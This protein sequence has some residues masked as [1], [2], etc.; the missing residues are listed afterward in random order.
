[1]KGFTLIELLIVVAIFGIMAAI[2]IPQWQKYKNPVKY[3]KARQER[4]R[5]E[6]LKNT[7]ECIAGYKFVITK[8]GTPVQIIGSNGH[9]VECFN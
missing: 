9:G 5:Q 6:V 8:D 4:L 7:H 1:M 3:E 2:A